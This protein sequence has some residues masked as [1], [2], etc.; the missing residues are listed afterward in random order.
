MTIASDSGIID[1]VPGLVGSFH[2]ELQADDGFGGVT[3]QQATVNVTAAGSNNLPQWVVG[4]KPTAIVQRQYA[5]Q[6][7]MDD[8]HEP[9]TFSLV[10]GPVGMTVFR[11]GQVQ[12]ATHGDRQRASRSPLKIPEV[13]ASRGQSR[14]QSS[15]EHRCQPQYPL[16]A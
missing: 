1:F 5:T 14:L 13:V 7:V 8:D 11:S 15:R 2:F 12:W 6:L 16:A 9:L 3:R 4:S 10:S